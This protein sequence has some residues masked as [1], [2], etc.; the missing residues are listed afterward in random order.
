MRSFARSLA[1]SLVLALASSLG[2]SNEAPPPAGAPASGAVAA[3]GLPDRDPALARKLVSEGAVLLDVRSPP[4][5]ASKHI[6]GAVNVPVDELDGRMAEVEKLAGGDAQKPIV[7]YCASGARAAQ[8]KRMLVKAGHTKVTNLG[9]I[10][11]WD[12]K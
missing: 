11:N 7:V 8:A 6:D 2:C 10:G 9:G 4:E 3:P 5:F 12:K 1:A